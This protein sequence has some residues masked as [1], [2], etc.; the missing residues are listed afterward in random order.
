[1]INERPALRK[2]NKGK[3]KIKIMFLE[4]DLDMI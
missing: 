2:I 1:M 3:S 4:Y